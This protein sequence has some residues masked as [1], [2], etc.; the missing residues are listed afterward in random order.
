MENANA[1]LVFDDSS[2]KPILKTEYIDSSNI[3]ETLNGESGFHIYH[4]RML[5]E[6]ILRSYV[7]K[8]PSSGLTDEEITSIS[9]ASSLHDIGKMKI[10]KSILEFPGRLSS[11]EYDI[12]KKHSLFGEEI[13]SSA[14]GDVDSSIIKHAKDI[15]RSHHERID[16]TGYP[17]GLKNKDIPLS[18][19]VVSLADSFDALTSVRSYKKAFSQDVA[20]EML[21]NGMSGVFDNVL[22][23]CLMEVV[24]N[25]MLLEIRENLRKR[26][27]VIEG[28]DFFT[29][30]RVLFLG[31][32]GYITY[33]FVEKTFPDA[34]TVILGDSSLKKRKNLKVY[35]VKSPSYR[36]VLNTYDF[37]LIV[38]FASD[39]TYKNALPSDSQELRTVLKEVKTCQ[40]NTRFIYL[41][42]PDSI[43]EGKSD[44][45][46]LSRAK[47][48]LCEYYFNEHA[49]DLKIIRIPY[50]F[51]GSYKNDF[52]YKLFDGAEKDNTVIL[53]EIDS[54]RCY[55]LSMFDLSD[56]LIRIT[57]NWKTGSGILDI[58]D[59]FNLT[60]HDIEK[61]F[62]S[63]KPGVRFEYS[64]ENPGEVLS[65]NNK[66]VRNEYGW[67]SKISIV[68]DL[69]EQYE[70]HLE[71]K[72]LILTT[73]YDKL[74]QWLKEHTLVMKIAELL[75]LFVVTEL[76][77]QL[78]GSS[79]IFS[80]VDFRMAYIVIMATIHGLPFG[81]AAAGLSS[82]S[83][84]IAKVSSGTNWMT[85]FYEPSNWFAFVF[86]FLVGAICGYIKL[87]N[88]DKIKYLDDQ[89]E[90]LE[91]KLIFTRDLYNDTFE[92]K[93]SLKKQ[94]ISSKDSFG[95][96]FDITRQL[97]TV[98]PRKLYLRIMDTFE[99]V[100]EN[101]S[102]SVYSVNEDSNFARLEVSSRDIISTTAR[103]ISLE[104]YAPV[105]EKLRKNEVWKNTD[106]TPGLP[107]YAAEAT[108]EG[109]LQIMI[110]IWHA[111]NNQKSLY[112][113]NLFKILC[114][115]VEMSLI[116][117]YDY[118]RAVFEKQYI[119]GTRILHTEDFE[120]V[121]E[122]FKNMS[123][124]KVFSYV[125][126]DI[127]LRGH[128][129][130]EA[131]DMIEKRIR[132][133]D[134]L[135]I[136]NEGRLR[137]LLSQATKD[138]LGFILPRFEGLDLDITVLD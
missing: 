108:R 54:S 42:S 119:S 33:D 85:I 70:K 97:D 111:G 130:E 101:K 51:S 128:S 2:G 90:L 64:G 134:V 126:L 46:F 121:Y 20:I 1:V 120:K 107:M 99:E 60:F 98:E 61:K 102:I 11:I 92:E 100:L 39:L 55:F 78:T 68:E 23:E 59:E 6:L 117:A 35:S 31:N 106:L 27:A 38:Y 87:K 124:R 116:R 123:G 115:L 7:K 63:I 18:A 24:N 45:A 16:G 12:V 81:I 36:R 65:F 136:N 41:S 93:R 86:F 69:E 125:Q 53:D 58:N 48:E 9:V 80:I 43:F 137:L 26:R 4:V 133:N 40:P 57:D 15:A 72:K 17:D 131:D 76:L 79:I 89:N 10:P 114:D 47:E 77:L 74:R 104:T 22:L 83:W 44:R 29:P 84:F 8:V 52:L 56:L 3:P 105:V 32:T 66:A 28:K 73:L 88:D 30:K 113:V 13:I 135:G 67:F 95:K 129:V 138:D 21:A 122:N 118:N 50:L 34:L 112:Y 110:F 37:D 14:E 94:I 62:A 5:T 19:Q 103:S 127:G 96:I 75:I 49:L 82:L 25:A 91:E 132:A 109:K 71:S